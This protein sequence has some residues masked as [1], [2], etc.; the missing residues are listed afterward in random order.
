MFP[1]YLPRYNAT[2]LRQVHSIFTNTTTQHPSIAPFSVY[3]LE[4]YS[5][6]AVN[7]VPEDSTAFP[8]RAY[9]IL[10]SPVWGYNDSSL[11]GTIQA[12]SR[13][14]RDAMVKGTGENQPLRGY[15]NYAFGDES[16]EELYG[17]EKWRV[18]KLKMLKRKWDPK[19]RF[20]FYAPIPVGN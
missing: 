5:H 11:A 15:V 19:G 2:A 1:T 18:Q 12:A 13:A 7:A 17:H 16:T 3:V 6:Q 9:P 14:I 10:S 20:G 4:G 8:N